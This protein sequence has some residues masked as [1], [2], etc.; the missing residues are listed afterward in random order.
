[1]INLS[2]KLNDKRLSDKLNRQ[3]NSLSLP[4]KITCE[5][6][7]KWVCFLIISKIIR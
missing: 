5:Y 2:D 4:I 1:M 7:I 3:W 6:K